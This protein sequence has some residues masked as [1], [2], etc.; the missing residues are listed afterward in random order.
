[1][2]SNVHRGRTKAGKVQMQI[3]LPLVPMRVR[4][5]PEPAPK[6]AQAHDPAIC[7]DCGQRS[8]IKYKRWYCAGCESKG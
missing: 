8:V 6:Q 5:L 1:M 4:N 2:S 7:G 3:L